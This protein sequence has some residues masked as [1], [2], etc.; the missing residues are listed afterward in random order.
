MKRSYTG[1]WPS[2]RHWKQEESHADPFGCRHP[3]GTPWTFA[4]LGGKCEVVAPS[5]YKNL[6]DISYQDI[7]MRSWP[8]VEKPETSHPQPNTRLIFRIRSTGIPDDTDKAK[9]ASPL[10]TPHSILNSPLAEAW[11]HMVLMQLPTPLHDLSGAIGTCWLSP[12]LIEVDLDCNHRD[13]AHGDNARRSPSDENVFSV[14][15]SPNVKD[16]VTGVTYVDTVT[17]SIGRVAI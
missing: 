7:T 16:K 10:R 6:W 5:S 9:P 2:L 13:H 8:L 3:K 1:G 11:G 14:S 17:T 12:E 15:T 4:S